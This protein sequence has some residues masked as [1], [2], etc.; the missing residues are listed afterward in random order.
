MA[1]VVDIEKLYGTWKLV[2]FTQHF[3]ATGETIDL[4]GRN[5]SGFLSYSR[6]G[7]MNAILVKDK[8]PRPADMAQ[9]T[10]EDMVQLFSSMYAY[11]GTFTIDGNT[12]THHVDISWN[13]N[14]T[15]TPQ[16][17]NVRLDG[18][19]LYISTNPQSNG[20]DE[21]IMVNELVW[22]KVR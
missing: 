20:I 1:R 2:S 15:G 10:A 21:R 8:R 11:A 5:P 6:D 17:R 4:F 22:V 12:V 3:V 16:L 7:R 14:W 9:V 18:E 19:K 13:E